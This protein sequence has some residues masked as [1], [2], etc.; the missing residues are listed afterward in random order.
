MAYSPDA[1]LGAMHTWELG[2]THTPTGI[3]MVCSVSPTG[4][5][6]EAQKDSVFQAFLDR[7]NGLNNITMDYARKTTLYQSN[8]TPT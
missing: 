1:D 3:K 6:T 2:F 4:T 8:V 7:V 5:G